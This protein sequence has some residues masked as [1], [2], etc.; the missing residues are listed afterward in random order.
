MI[1]ERSFS[2]SLER[3]KVYC[4]SKKDLEQKDTDLLIAIGKCSKKCI[5]ELI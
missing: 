3:R 1:L 4:V 2:F 5:K